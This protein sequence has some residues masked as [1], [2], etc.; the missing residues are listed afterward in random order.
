MN[1]QKQ[2]ILH[3]GTLFNALNRNRRQN[4][5][6]R[7]ENPL[8]ASKLG[9]LFALRTSTYVNFKGE[10]VTLNEQQLLILQEICVEHFNVHLDKEIRNLTTLDAPEPTPESSTT[11]TSSGFIGKIKGFFK[12]KPKV[13]EHHA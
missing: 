8:I 12:L 13:Q 3:I 7:I 4:N 5:L 2:Y 6:E 1:E 9:I 10:Y 11:P